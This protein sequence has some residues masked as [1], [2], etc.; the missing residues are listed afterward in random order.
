M[1]KRLRIFKPGRYGIFSLI[2]DA[3]RDSL[4][5]KI[6]V[7]ISKTFESDSPKDEAILHFKYEPR[8]LQ[9][10]PYAKKIFW[11][12]EALPN[13]IDHLGRRPWMFMRRCEKLFN[14]G[15]ADYI[16]DFSPLN[17]HV[18]RRSGIPSEHLAMGYH[19]RFVFKDQ[20]NYDLYLL[21]RMS[22][23]RRLYRERIEKD[24]GIRI[25]NPKKFS[26][27]C[28]NA[29]HIHLHYYKDYFSF[30]AIRAALVFSN[31][32]LLITEECDWYPAQ[33][34]HHLIV[35]NRGTL[36][37]LCKRAVNGEFE[38]V[39]QDGYKYYRDNCRFDSSVLDV[40]ARLEVI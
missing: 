1:V 26:L 7:V 31:K 15:W 22:P 3:I 21:G 27:H 24:S 10:Y 17:T 19:E 4:I 35:G 20:E 23:R 30:E 40:M 2:S 9:E 13:G 39:R 5:G 11:N 25:A 12:C 6:E 32:N 8:G 29:V 36:G 16:L 37:D 38:K 28:P 33:P 34:G 14:E 18:L